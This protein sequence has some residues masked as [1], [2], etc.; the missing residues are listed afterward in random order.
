LLVL[1]FFP[2]FDPGS[3]QGELEIDVA[4]VARVLHELFLIRQPPHDEF[5]AVRPG[6]GSRIIQRESVQQVRVIQRVGATGTYED[7]LDPDVAR[8][9]TNIL[10][11]PF[12]PKRSGEL[13][14][15]VNDA[16]TAI[17]WLQDYFYRN[18]S[19]DGTITVKR[20]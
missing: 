19:G 5:D 10:D 11:E 15:Y 20:Q 4:F 1:C 6:P 14:I 16:V 17:P 2:L 18:N 3:G 9:P 13:F 8:R 7:F 12:T